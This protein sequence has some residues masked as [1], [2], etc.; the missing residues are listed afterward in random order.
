MFRGA[1]FVFF[2]GTALLG[3][4]FAPRKPSERRPCYRTAL[5]CRRFD[6]DARDDS[7]L[8]FTGMHAL[9]ALAYK[10]YDYGLDDVADVCPEHLCSYFAC[11]VSA[12]LWDLR[13]PSLRRRYFSNALCIEV[14]TLQHGKIGGL[15]QLLDDRL[16]ISD[17]NLETF[18]YPFVPGHISKPKECKNLFLVQ[19]PERK[20]SRV[21]LREPEDNP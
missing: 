7:G 13:R 16:N 15:K 2:F 8:V 1:F 3:P 12:L 6:D 9:T 4:L 20:V 14:A 21:S 17:S 11:S 5:V 18:M 10:E 19:M